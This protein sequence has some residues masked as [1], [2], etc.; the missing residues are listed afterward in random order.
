MPHYRHLVSN[1]ITPQN[2]YKSICIEVEYN[3]TLHPP[4]FIINPL[5]A[6]GIIICMTICYR[7]IVISNA[8]H[9]IQGLWMSLSTLLNKA[10]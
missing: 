4:I 7:D 9:A 2:S 3:T 5:K 8:H 6:K 1:L 10:C